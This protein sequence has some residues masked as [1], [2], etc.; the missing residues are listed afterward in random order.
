[1]VSSIIS[2]IVTDT[3]EIHFSTVWTDYSGY[4]L[5]SADDGYVSI[6]SCNVR[7]VGAEAI[8]IIEAL[9]K[10]RI[11]RKQRDPAVFG[12]V[13]NNANASYKENGSVQLDSDTEWANDLCGRVRVN[14]IGEGAIWVTNING[15]ITNG[16]YL[17]SSEIAGHAEKQGDDYMYNY[18][19]AKATISCSFDLSSSN[20]RCEEI[21]H[22]QSTFLRA[23]IGCT[24]HCG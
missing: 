21:V 3:D 11:T 14:S 7:L 10:T 18:T 15:D 12:V 13:T 22:K 1:M 23:Y 8:T 5:S 6:P 9:P 17:C 4:L 19:V 16:D 2:T 20:Y 24:Y